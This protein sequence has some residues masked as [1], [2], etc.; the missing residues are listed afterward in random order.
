MLC[1]LTALSSCGK[2]ET[3]DQKQKTK[4][5]IKAL[6]YA[7]PAFVNITQELSDVY[8]SINDSV[9][10][11][12]V[13]L[14]EDLAIKKIVNDSAVMAVVSRPLFA[15]EA[16]Q[17]SSY[18][19][20]AK[21]YLFAHDALAF[22]VNRADKDSLLSEQDIINTLTNN[23]KQKKIVF[24]A[25]YSSS[26]GAVENMLRSDTLNKYSFATKN[27]EE[28]FNFVATNTNA[29]GI[30]GSNTYSNIDDS[31]LAKLFS[32]VRLVGVTVS[33]KPYYPFQADIAAK[34]YPFSRNIYI[35]NSEHFYGKYSGFKNF[36][37]GLKGQRIVLKSGLMPIDIPSRLLNF[38]KKRE[39]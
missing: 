8:E 15:H 31:T 4:P 17:L 22:V 37:I 2:K 1:A 10:F 26:I 34:K 24:E 5:R 14:A 16:E 20:V 9:D 32:K 36:V 12:V 18:Q 30:L 23:P 38:V 3:T 13:P 35:I 6:I 11:E 39:S 21:D 7:D 19:K 33:K 25:N 29:I 28:L 27:V